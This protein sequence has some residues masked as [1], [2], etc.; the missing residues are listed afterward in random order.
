MAPASVTRRMQIRDG[1]GVDGHPRYEDAELHV[2][3][4]EA[5]LSTLTWAIA[6]QRAVSHQAKD[7]GSR[8][9]GERPR[10]GSYLRTVWPRLV[11]NLATEPSAVGTVP[12]TSRW[13][14]V[15]A[16]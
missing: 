9:P 6:H 2:E 14:V 4:S 15:S 1:A 13:R 7:T 11:M 16:T 3:V 5:D 8:V 10:R 12:N